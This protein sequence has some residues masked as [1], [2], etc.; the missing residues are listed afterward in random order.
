[1]NYFPKF[2]KK[3]K[4]LLRVEH[5]KGMIENS[6]NWFSHL[7]KGELLKHLDRPGWKRESIAYLLKRLGEEVAE[8]CDAIE[9]NQPKEVVEKE[10]ADVANFSMMIADIYRQKSSVA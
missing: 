10:A 3:E 1:M 7:M 6:V 8:L 4:E 2:N 5:Q 9:T